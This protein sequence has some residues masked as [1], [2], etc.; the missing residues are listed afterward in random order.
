MRP[1]IVER[2]SAGLQGTNATAL[3][4]APTYNGTLGSLDKFS[5]ISPTVHHNAMVHRAGTDRDTSP[6]WPL[7]THPPVVSSYLAFVNQ[8]VHPGPG[9]ADDVFIMSEDNLEMGIRGKE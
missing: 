4:D 9:P 7:A 6:C 5:V 3:F 8:W 1:V 2:W